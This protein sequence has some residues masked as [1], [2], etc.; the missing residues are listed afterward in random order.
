MSSSIAASPS[1]GV[2]AALQLELQPRLPFSQMEQAD[3][4]RFI[5]QAQQ[6]YY[7]AGE[8]I[9]TPAMGDVTEVFFVRRGSVSAP[10]NAPGCARPLEAK[11]RGEVVGPQ[12]QL[13]CPKTR[14]SVRDEIG[15]RWYAWQ[16]Q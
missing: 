7:D 16:A 8:V 1:P 5:T 12:H 9:V 13:R 14:S 10:L 6:R 11:Q 2:L 3:I 4:Q 15:T